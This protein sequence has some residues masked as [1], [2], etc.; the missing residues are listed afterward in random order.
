VATAAPT[1]SLLAQPRGRLFVLPREHGAWAMLLVPLITGAVAGYPHGEHLLSVSLFAAAAL[2]LFCLRIPVEALL[3]KSANRPQNDA[4]RRLVHNFIYFYVSV[5]GSALVGLML[6]GSAYGLLLLGAVAA[7]AFI[8]QDVLRHFG[9]EA[10][11]SAQFV[12]AVALSSTSAGTYY[13]AT[14]RFDITAGVIW[15][16]NWLFAADQI[17]F[18]QLRIRSARIPSFRGKFRQGRGFLLHEALSLLILVF[19]WRAEW[20]PGLVLLAFGLLFIRG[21]AWFVEAPRALQVRRLGL[22][23]LLYAV[24]FGLLFVVGFHHPI[25]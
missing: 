4:E 16:A 23:E 8:L 3:E 20:L 6:K 19:I 25:W 11:M 21:V 5:A 2:G 12:G 1:L 15:L 7:I 14:G 22:S 24:V 13:L 9:R 18:V 10:R 17:H